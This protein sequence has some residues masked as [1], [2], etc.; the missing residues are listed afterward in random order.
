MKNFTNTND[1]LKHIVKHYGEL[2]FKFSYTSYGVEFDWITNISE[3]G[4]NKKMEEI[5]FKFDNE[6]H[7][8]YELERGS[9]R[10][11]IITQNKSG[12]ACQ[13]NYEWNYSELGSKNQDLIELIRNEINSRLSDEIGLSIF[14]FTEK[15]YYKLVF[16][17]EDTLDKGLFL[18]SEWEN[19]EYVEISLFTW[20]KIKETIIELSIENGANTSEDVCKFDYEFDNENGWIVEKWSN[21]IDDFMNFFNNDVF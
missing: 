3:F 1:F 12:L 15:Y 6:Y 10:E 18:L 20:G 16:S 17:S 7:I 19:E 9:S 13:I 11:Y 21:S 4:F 14:D 5:L 2:R 8:K